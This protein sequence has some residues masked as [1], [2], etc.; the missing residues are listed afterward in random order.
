MWQFF[1]NYTTSCLTTSISEIQDKV[2]L[3]FYPNPFSTKIKLS[4][5]TGFEDF[6]LSNSIGQSIWLGKNIDKQDFSYLTSGL[7]F[8]KVD[9]RIYKLIKE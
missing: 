8:V 9:N 6:I 4:N 5:T 7:Y 2:N 1:Q 3:S